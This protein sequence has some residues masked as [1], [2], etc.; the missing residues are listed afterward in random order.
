MQYNQEYTRNRI[1]KKSSNEHYQVAEW[2][3][4]LK[5]YK[6]I[7]NDAPKIVTEKYGAD[8]VE[9]YVDIYQM[10]VEV[11]NGKQEN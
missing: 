2:L 4:E 6:E 9:G 7:I 11:N 10:L 5:A 3:K 1:V 8:I